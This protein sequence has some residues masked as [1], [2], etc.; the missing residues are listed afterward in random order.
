MDANYVPAIYNKAIAYKRMGD[1]SNYIAL[2]HKVVYI[3]PDFLYAWEELVEVYKKSG[4]KEKESEALGK[5][6]ELRS[7]KS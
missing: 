2:L 6:I 3:N 4:D 1:E 5:V 7:K